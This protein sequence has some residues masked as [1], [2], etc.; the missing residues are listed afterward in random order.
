[1][2]MTTLIKVE[3]DTLITTPFK[4]LLYLG[5]YLLEIITAILDME[6]QPGLVSLCSGVTWVF[7]SSTVSAF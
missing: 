5:V 7:S 2:A 4:E 6:M 1:M 3:Q